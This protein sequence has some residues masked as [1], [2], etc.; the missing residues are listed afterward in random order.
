MSKE[1]NRPTNGWDVLMSI[2]QGIF[3]V[4]VLAVMAQCTMP[5]AIWPAQVE[6][7]K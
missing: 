1:D 5:G 3:L 6:K 7:S 4:I 2:T